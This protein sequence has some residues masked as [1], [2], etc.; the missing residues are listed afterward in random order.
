MKSFFHL[1]FVVVIENGELP[2]W[3]WDP[4]IHSGNGLLQMRLMT[5]KVEAMIAL[6]HCGD[7]VRGVVE[8]FSIWRSSFFPH[9]TQDRV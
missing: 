3:W 6:R 4:G 1:D 9:D 2:I 8:F 5:K 7:V